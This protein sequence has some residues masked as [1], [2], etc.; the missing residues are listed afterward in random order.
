MGRRHSEVAD[1]EKMVP[2]KVVGGANELVQVEVNGKLFTPPQ[3]SAYILTLEI[4]R[5]S[6]TCRRATRTFPA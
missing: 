3:V 6:A 1:E 5:A 2:Y 4:A